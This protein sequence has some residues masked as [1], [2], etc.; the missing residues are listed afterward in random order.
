MCASHSCTSQL[1]MGMVKGAGHQLRTIDLRDVASALCADAD[2]HP[3]E[4]LLAQQQHGLHH[5]EAQ[6]VWLHQLQG[7]ACSPPTTAKGYQMAC[8]CVLTFQ[9]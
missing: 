7:R 3:A 6:R 5:L 2:V 1:E 4:A 8:Q 9:N